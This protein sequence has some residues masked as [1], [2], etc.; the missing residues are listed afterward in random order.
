MQ[1]AALD[2]R[3]IVDG[4]PREGVMSYISRKLKDLKP[5][6]G[7]T[8]TKFLFLV[9]FVEKLHYY[10]EGAVF[11]VHTECTENNSCLNMKTTNRHMLRLQIAIQEYRGNMTIICKEGKGHTNA[12][13]ISRWPLDNFKSHPD[14]A[15][16]I[17]IHLIQI[18]RK[19]TFIF[20]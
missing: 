6:Y 17:P 20:S 7:E 2:Q 3:Q 11:E 14:S 5:R 10:F 13:G 8:Q 18:D 19:K 16:K 4:E 1:L 9:L 12:D 15:A